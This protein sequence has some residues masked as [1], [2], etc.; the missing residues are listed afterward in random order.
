M[1]S[2]VNNKDAEECMREL[3]KAE[4]Y[5]LDKTK[6]HGETGVDILATKGRESFHIEVIGY[7]S[8][9]PARA[10]DFFEAFFRV[11]SR[12]NNGA[13]HCVIAM[14][15]QAVKGLPR[16]AEQY[17][18]AWNRIEK[19][20]PELEVWLIDVENRTYERAEWGVWLRKSENVN[21]NGR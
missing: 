16:R 4:G 11:I 8:S 20:F 19:A 7:K 17:R 14:P 21:G 2:R 12:L 1:V 9:G 10:R 3:L 5:E 13:T 15:K 6:K 18:I